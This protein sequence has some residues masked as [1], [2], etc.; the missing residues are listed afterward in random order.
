MSSTEER[1]SSLERQL[2]RTRRTAGVLTCVLAL[3]CI[4]GAGGPP[5]VSL[6]CKEVAVKDDN[7]TTVVKLGGNGNGDD[8]GPLTVNNTDVLAEIKKF[9]KLTVKQ[10]VIDRIAF[11]HNDK[12]FGE[13]NFPAL[14]TALMKG[15]PG[16]R[17]GKIRIP[18]SKRFDSKPQV[19]VTINSFDAKGYIAVTDIT[20]RDFEVNILTDRGEI[21]TEFDFSYIAIE[22]TF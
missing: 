12:Q 8:G 16:Q 11:R 9:Q 18:F 4:V 19:L 6:V 5:L 15:G 20:E 21:M 1:L 7:G 14:W 2:R 13:V 22:P 17:G 10:I 3:V